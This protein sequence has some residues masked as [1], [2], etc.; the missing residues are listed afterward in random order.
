MSK[1]EIVNR[2][3]LAKVA[4]EPKPDT[5]IDY[6]IELHCAAEQETGRRTGSPY[7]LPVS[8]FPAWTGE[9]DDT[10]LFEFGRRLFRVTVDALDE[11]E[12]QR[13]RWLAVHDADQQD[14]F[15]EEM[16]QQMAQT[17]SEFDW[18][19]GSGKRGVWMARLGAVFA[20]YG[21]GVFVSA[22][23]LISL[24]IGRYV[25]GGDYGAAGVWFVG[26]I[27]LLGAAAF[28]VRHL[29]VRGRQ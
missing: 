27:P 2:E 17:R 5:L 29:I 28:L 16:R 26:A 7:N 6:L 10:T 9:K 22:L 15:W 14:A 24:G 18:G 4:R 23:V 3:W 1:H 12:T 11:Q 8:I 13:L 20:G 21:I 19:E 25:R